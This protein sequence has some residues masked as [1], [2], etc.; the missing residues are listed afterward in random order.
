MG[1]WARVHEVWPDVVISSTAARAQ[2]TSE[3]FIEAGK[4]EVPIVAEPRLYHCTARSIVELVRLRSE[5]AVMIVGH[6][7]GLEELVEGLTKQPIRFVTAA[8]AWIELPI[9]SW[10]ELSLEVKGHLRA[11]WKPK[12]LPETR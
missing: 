10:S 7:P 5:H 4:Y 3:A 8:F 12:E 9:A 2:L 11:L 1:R 6:N